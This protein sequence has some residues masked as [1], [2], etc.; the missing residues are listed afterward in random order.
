MPAKKKAAPAKKPA[1]KK[2]AA[3]KP[4]KTA[5]KSVGAEP[6]Y[7]MPKEVSEWIE[8]AMSRMRHMQSEIDRLKT[9]NRDLKSY[10]KFAEQRILRSDYE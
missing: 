6:V 4:V 10:K 5:T 1:A 7:S 9:E 3:K 8:N 2:V